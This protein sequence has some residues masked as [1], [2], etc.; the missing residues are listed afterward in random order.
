LNAVLLDTPALVWL[1]VGDGWQRLAVRRCIETAAQ[2]RL[3]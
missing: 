3:W 2:Q 1:V